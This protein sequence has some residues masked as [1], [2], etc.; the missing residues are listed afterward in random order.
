MRFS[1]K[2]KGDIP[3]HFSLSFSQTMDRF[4]RVEGPEAKRAKLALFKEIVGACVPETV[5]TECLSAVQGDLERAI[6]MYY[7]NVGSA[8]NPIRIEDDDLV[9]PSAS[10]SSP[11]QQ[12][13]R[14]VHPTF[15]GSISCLGSL[16]TKLSAAANELYMDTMLNCTFSIKPPSGS[17]SVY[18]NTPPELVEILHGSGF[19]RFSL[20]SNRS[21]IGRLPAPL[22]A[23]IVPLV[24]LGLADVSLSVGFPGCAG[25]NLSPGASVPIRVDVSLLPPAMNSNNLQ[26]F[27]SSAD[28]M[29]MERVHQCWSTVLS[30]MNV[31][32]NTPSGTTSTV[33]PDQEEPSVPEVEDLG[34]ESEMSE[35]MSKLVAEYAK[36]D[37]ALMTPPSDI[38]PTELKSYQCQALFWMASREYPVE[39]GGLPQLV[40]DRCRFTNMS[41]ESGSQEYTLPASW[42]EIKT[43]S[44]K[45]LFYKE[46]RFQE[47]RPLPEVECRGGILAD[48]M[49]LGK[50]VMTLSLISLDLIARSNNNIFAQNNSSSSGGLI[51]G[52][53]LVVVH[54][55]LLRQWVNE[56]LRHCPQL[57]YSEFHGADRSFDPKSLA[58][59]DVVFT[60]YGT[61]AVN[62][63][64][65][66]S[67]LLKIAWRRIVLDEAH[68]IR[69]RSTKM[70]KA[71]AR[72]TAERRWCLTGTPLQNSIA[73]IYPLVAWLRVSPW[74]SYAYFKK[75]ILDVPSEVGCV[76]AQNML[77][78]LMI[79]RTKSMKGNDENPLVLLPSRKNKIVRIEL[80]PEEKDFYRALFWKTKL[81][82]DKF[83]KSN[84]V[85][86]NITHVLQLIVRLRQAL[87]HPILCRSALATDLIEAG[88][89]NSVSSLDELLDKFITKAA[90]NASS[91]FFQ[92]AIEDL[93]R[94]GI[95]NLECPICLSEPCQFPIMTPCGHTMCR[96]C[97]MGRLRGECPICRTVFTNGEIQNINHL[98][99]G[100]A[101]F[102][103]TVICPPLSSKLRVLMDYLS[104]DLNKG[105]RVIVFSQFV[106]F[107]EIIA[108]VFEAKKIPFRT[109]H[110]GH[111]TVQRDSAVD[112]LTNADLSKDDKSFL[113]HLSEH[114][115]EVSDDEDDGTVEGEK[116]QGRVLLV[117][118][119]AGGTGLNL[120]AANV[121]YLTDLWWNGAIEEQAF[122]RVHRIAQTK[123]TLTYKFVCHDTIDE[124]ILDLQATKRDMTSD[125]LGDKDLSAPGTGN[126]DRTRKLTLE[127]IRQLFKPQQ[128]SF[129]T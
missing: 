126:V 67:S 52:G 109:F 54:L 79:R 124:R 6:N 105:R 76:N 114:V 55:S 45:Q 110:G 31:I 95:E 119:K 46:G 117:S 98:V 32:H 96:K 113:G 61:T 25:L 28:D 91:E 43:A 57:T 115:I 101:S 37:L 22:A 102:D 26:G 72:L 8:L 118:L 33:T 129:L 39:L 7:N 68:S 29:K 81:E 111:T 66:Q 18:P 108:K 107:I 74:K 93:K 99:R 48:E 64:N 15:L 120:V 21:E 71:V 41:P 106:S 2:K 14:I 50:T 65:G 12:I 89:Q 40:R 103:P 122:N 104:R 30:H 75:E 23:A 90:P 47:E 83:E 3:S 128:G 82:F 42:T 112:W 4:I 5:A 116:T 10:S 80:S 17:L 13:S 125:V 38:F 1:I 69:T 121:V 127:D 35:E 11:P 77:K 60:T 87:C 24:K 86:F 44:D 92:N 84:A 9:I 123:K 94:V 56:L 27:S 100:E 36:S 19:V 20:P 78:P 59:V 58:S 62:S 51:K 88:T 70:G 63:E 34:Q 49:G 97:V 53:T 73:D 85:M 16:T